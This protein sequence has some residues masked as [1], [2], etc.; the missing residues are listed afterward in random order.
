M[1]RARELSGARVTVMG[2]G[3]FG[4]GIGVTRYLVDQGA[5]VLVTDLESREKLADSV[6]QI[7]DFVESGRVT[8]RLGEH[9]VSDFTTCDLVVANPA[10]PRPWE[11]RFLRSAEAAGVRITTEIQLAVDA[12]TPGARIVAI[13]GSAGKSTTSALVHHILTELGERV[14]FGGNIGGS[15]LARAA[16][17]RD[18]DAVVLELS[19]F[20]LHWLRDF[21]PRV[22]AVTNLEPNHLDWHVTL[23][24][25]RDSKR[26]VLQGQQPGG[27]AVLGA[28]V[29]DW[30]TNAGVK[31][32]IMSDSAYIPGLLIPGAHNE[33]NAAMAIEVCRAVVH[34]AGRELN[35]RAAIAAAQTFPGLPHRLRHVGVIRG[36]RFYDDSKSTTPQATMLALDS[37]PA[38][39]AAGRIH[40]IAGGYDKG[41]DLSPIAF[42][43]PE[44]KG[45][46][47]IG[48][49]GEWIAQAA[50]GAPSGHRV[51][52]C[53]TL[54]RAII[55]I[56]QRAEPGDIVLLSPGCASWDQFQNYE[57]RGARFAA[58]ANETFAP[59]RSP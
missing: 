38:E 22:A 16:D 15:L 35:E 13:T 14:H 49:T 7:S 58:L 1:A 48:R 19:S 26:R 8:L 43:A 52:P 24:H 2:L 9:N 33:V 21:H 27:V 47:T 11:N 40:L 23:D 53:M 39:R 30:P 46:Y 10:V 6:A 32:V 12:I 31:R 54:E 18:T 57:E 25:Y 17:V 56:A 44:L 5:D 42:A 50:G 55:A 28:G 37:F 4:G 59:V 3:R 36:I 20:Q 29:A 51:F 41:Q 45:L 34:T